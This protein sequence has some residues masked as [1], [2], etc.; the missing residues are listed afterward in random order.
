[1]PEHADEQP[2]TREKALTAGCLLLLVLVADVAAGMLVLILLAVRGLDRANAD[3]GQAVAGTPPADWA[4][5]LCHGALALAVGV[6][7]LVLL[8]LGH[9]Y[10][11]AARLVLCIVLVL[12]FPAT[13]G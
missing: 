11:G 8:R 13:G 4:P 1:M 5:V 12:A 6:T 2:S 3:S 9:R 7:G 10:I